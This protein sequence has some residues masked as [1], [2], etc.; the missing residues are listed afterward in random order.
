MHTL[1]FDVYGTLVDTSGVETLLEHKLGERT[2]QFSK[3]WRNKQLEYSFRMGLMRWYQPFSQCTRYAFE[4]TCEEFGV[5]FS[6]N[7]KEALFLRYLSLPAFADA[8]EALPKFAET[9]AACFAFSNGVKDDV[10]SVLTYAGVRPYLQDVISV[11]AVKVFKPSRIA[12]MYMVEQIGRWRAKDRDADGRGEV[13]HDAL[14]ES[15]PSK[16]LHY[17]EAGMDD[18]DDDRLLLQPELETVWLISSNPFDVIG[19]RV[20]GLQAVWIRRSSAS[21]FDP[22]GVEPTFTVET[23]TELFDVLRC[24]NVILPI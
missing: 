17:V 24:R 4:Y 11:D 21:I 16:C 20:A 2:A 23:L 14:F 9:D 22:W 8:A 7:E 10:E 3:Q 1:V 5:S 13:P 18:A 19:A 12:Y 6:D 15:A